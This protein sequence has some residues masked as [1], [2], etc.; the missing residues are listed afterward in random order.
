MED[1]YG[2]RTRNDRP[3][4]AAFR[5]EPTV[6]WQGSLTSHSSRLF[7]YRFPGKRGPKTEG[8]LPLPCS[9]AG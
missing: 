7:R 9:G 3:V 1:G 5:G 2:R 8:E 6:P 4:I